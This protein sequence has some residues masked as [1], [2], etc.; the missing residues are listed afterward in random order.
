MFLTN[1]SESSC[2]DV[3]V[4][5]R[6]LANASHPTIKVTNADDG[7]ITIKTKTLIKS[8]SITFKIDE[9]FEETRQDDVKVKSKVTR[10]GNT[11]HQVMKGG[12][13]K[14]TVDIVREFREDG[15]H[16]EAKVNGI[17]CVRFYERVKSKK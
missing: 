16:V 3:N 1:Y 10:D 12:D 8:S 7:S 11:L 2:L 4:I 13:E 5:I 17:T 15:L 14:K 9:E 6:K